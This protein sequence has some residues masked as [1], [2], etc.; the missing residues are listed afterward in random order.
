MAAGELAYI[1]FSSITKISFQGKRPPAISCYE[2]SNGNDQYEK[3]K[4]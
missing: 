4:I 3:I 1:F 2:K